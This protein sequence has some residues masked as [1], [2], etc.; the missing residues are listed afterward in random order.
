MYIKKL[1]RNSA[2]DI[3][4]AIGIILVVYGHVMRG[5]YH[6]GI[7]NSSDFFSL[8]DSI[9]Y[10]FHMPLFFFLSGLFFYGS[11]TKRGGRQ[12]LL[13]KVDTILYPYIIW[14]LIQGFIEVSASSYTNNSINISDVVALLWAPRAQFWFLYALFF[15]FVLS[16]ILN[17][18]FKKYFL[19]SIIVFALLSYFLVIEFKLPN[20]INIIFMNIIFF[21]FGI[22]FYLSGGLDKLGSLTCT[23]ILLIAFVSAQYL[24]HVVL[25]LYHYDRGIL[26]L[27][28]AFISIAFV[29]SLS[30]TI[31]EM[32][33]KTGILTLLGSVSLVIFLLHVIV[34]SGIRIVLQK[35]F[36]IDSFTLHLIVGTLFGLWIPVL[37]AQK[38]EH[39]NLMYLFHA[40]IS[41]ILV[42]S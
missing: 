25:N 35:I 37:I 4:K 18:V 3:A 10:S 26:S 7:S 9:I 41:R 24:F 17:T 29:I 16:V 38:T 1:Q 36:G 22:Y 23:I 6:S 11:V 40:P 19:F 2:V 15:I 13:N 32:F 21:C 14:S 33:A 5:L 20:I 28:L 12:F 30:I 27:L 34:A 39:N 31:N 8:S 42:R